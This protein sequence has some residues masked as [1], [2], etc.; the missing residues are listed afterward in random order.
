MVC[1]YSGNI[2]SFGLLVVYED[3]QQLENA[4]CSSLAN[5]L[6]PFIFPNDNKTEA[7]LI[8]PAAASSYPNPKLY[9]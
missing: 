8:V 1:I 3:R 5:R 6:N 2:C 4:R 9:S 7:K